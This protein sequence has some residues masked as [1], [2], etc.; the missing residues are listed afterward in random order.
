MD[1]TGEPKGTDPL[2]AFA[3]RLRGA[4]QNAG[5]LSV[6]D[7]EKLSRD[8]GN[9]YS[10]Q[11]FNQKLNG[12]SKPDWKFVET[13]I[14]AC[15]RSGGR[16]VSQPELD[17]WRDAH[18]RFLSE[19]AAIRN[20]RRE[21]YRGTAAAVR[22]LTALPPDD[23]FVRERAAYLALLRDRFDALDHTNALAAST[24]TR[25]APSLP[26]RKMFVPQWVRAEPLQTELPREA[27]LELLTHGRFRRRSVPDDVDREQLD[28]EAKTY[29]DI[30]RR[31]VLEVIAERDRGG[32]VVL[33][34]PGAG[35]STLAAYLML[36]IADL[37]SGAEASGDYA[38][39]ASLADHLPILIEL[40]SY[41][42][43]GG[44]RE[45]LDEIDHPE[46]GRPGLPRRVL[47][48]YL[49]QGGPA[50][51]IFD[52]L[53]EVFNL[54]RR[55]GI[56][57]QVRQFAKA[58]PSVRVVVTSRKT[59]YLRRIL[60]G[61]KFGHYTLQDLEPAQVDLFVERFYRA[62]DPHRWEA[63]T[64]R[65]L[66]TIANSSAFAELAGNPMLLTALAL[67]GLRSKLPPHRRR[68]L[69][70]TVNILVNRWDAEKYLEDNLTPGQLSRNIA[71]LLDDEE[72]KIDLLRRV[73]RS[74]QQG[75]KGA[76]GLEGN[77]LSRKALTGVITDFLSPPPKA[78]FAS[79]ESGADRAEKRNIADILINQF[80]ERDYIIAKFGSDTFGFVHR[81]LLDYLAADDINARFSNQEITPEY[82]EKLF[83]DYAAAPDWQEV[84]LLL[85][86]MIKN[87]IVFEGAVAEL[88]KSNPLWYLSND[89]LPRHVILAVRCLG[90][91]RQPNHVRAASCDVANAL[92]TMLET[93]IAADDYPLAVALTEALKQHV[94]PVL[95][96]LGPAWEGQPFYET[97]YLCRGQFLRG[98]S[99]G[100]AATAA[101]S[102]YVALLGD[103]EQARDRLRTLARWADSE[104]VRGAALE[105]LAR[106]WHREPE[107]AELLRASATDDPESYVRRVAVGTVAASW[108]RDQQTHELL[109]D[110][111]ASEDE[112]PAV[113]ATAI[114]WLASGWRGPATGDLLR[115]IGA[116]PAVRGEVRAVAVA[117]VASGW[118]ND[119][120]TARWLWA[121]ASDGDARVRIAT[122]HALARG[123]HDDPETR[124]WLCGH[125]ADTGEP[126]PKA[127]VTAV[128]L[129]AAG[130]PD[131]PDTLELLKAK[132]CPGGDISTEV[133]RAA[134]EALAA[135]WRDDPGTADWLL[136][137]AEKEPDNDVRCA[138]VQALA[139][140]WPTADATGELLDR[141]AHAE[142]GD[143]YV[144]A[145]AV[146]ALAVIRARQSRTGGWLRARAI[147]DPKPLVRQV[148]LGAAAAGWQADQKTERWLRGRVAATGEELNVRTAAIRALAAGWHDNQTLERLRD[149][150]EGGLSTGAMRRVALQAVA[151]GWRDD[152]RTRPWLR[153]H[154]VKD[155]SPAVRRTALQLLA[156]DLRWHDDQETVSLLRDSVLDDSQFPEVRKAAVR[157]L[158]AGWRD[159]P[160]TVGWL[161]DIAFATKDRHVK[162][163]VI[164]TLATDWHDDPATPG[165]LRDRA[166]DDED[167][168]VRQEAAD[169][170]ARGWPEP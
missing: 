19:L 90:E 77:Y 47:E 64:A 114:R 26:L 45:F 81:A 151:S 92:I 91:V 16:D 110:R 71:A 170:V 25:E 60:D 51:V 167:K 136:A 84:L 80:R 160:A 1:G 4:V 54:K 48:P 154:A 153:Q 137:R 30:P 88:L 146:Q 57:W 161:R 63:L 72:G 121:R 41:A 13:L 33:G 87:P 103:G 12:R 102:I 27:R 61:A 135:G 106:N 20:N 24:D 5:D 109:C 159:D 56:Q 29:A 38:G 125:T 96:R 58:Y 144:R 94:L 78:E 150:G 50:L 11:T 140:Y 14:T 43:D 40:R 83:R 126:S 89:P 98:D 143:W 141:L 79:S 138:L 148:A 42:A 23:E 127:R 104:M 124:P 52:G 149:A 21:R 8:L 44:K 100:F 35:K 165:W 82:I 163:A 75:N 129:I 97:W 105:A 17:R 62:T 122:A 59:G 119:K 166:A 7:L 115:A 134:V 34:D 9:P 118:H 164:R 37:A 123:W 120:Q 55:E 76:S 107:I 108:P 128:R 73:A 85:A 46:L 67:L 68:V 158:S 86:G 147:D 22:E 155:K 36:A 168:Q 3:Y 133:R 112:S 69:E 99:P 101:A 130:W 39:L 49:T 70:H 95:T 131:Q 116:D 169:W 74:I 2:A 31:P 32:I 117:E 28:L 113:R 142:D 15:A 139:A 10:R 6:R 157:T 152:E 18:G 66:K 162:L 53:D 93:V 132:A 111:A 145:T 65:L 156:A